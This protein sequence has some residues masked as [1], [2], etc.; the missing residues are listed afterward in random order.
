[1]INVS[2]K[3]KPNSHGWRNKKTYKFANCTSIL[4]NI[5]E[6]SLDIMP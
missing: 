1:M 3:K 4:M 2:I 6:A 5:T